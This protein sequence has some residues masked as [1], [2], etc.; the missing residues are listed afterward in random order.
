[1]LEGHEGHTYKAVVVEDGGEDEGEMIERGGLG[2]LVRIDDDSM[3]VS[4]YHTQA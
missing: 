4:V 1:M 3:I 2:A